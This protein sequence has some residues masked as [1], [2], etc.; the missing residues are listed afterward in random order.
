MKVPAAAAAL[1]PARSGQPETT[2]I[3]GVDKGSVPGETESR[4]DI[5]MLVRVSPVTGKAAVISIPRDTRVNMP[6]H[7]KQKINA[8]HAFGGPALTIKTVEEFTGQ[9][10]NHYVELDFQGF[11]AIVNALGGVK[12]HIDVAIHD[13]YAGDVPAGDVNLNG[14]QAL[15]LVRARHD[16]KSVP[17]GDLDR[18]KNQRRFLQAMLSTISRQRNPF[19]LMD[20]V[21]A[22]SKNAKTD[23]TFLNMLGMGRKLKGGDLQM[24]TL[25]GQPRMIGD[26]WYYI[27]DMGAFEQVLSAL[28]SAQASGIE[29]ADKPQSVPRAA[30]DSEARSSVKVAVLNG[31]RVKGVAARVAQQIISLGYAS[32]AAANAASTY[33]RTTIY[34]ASGQSAK[35]R[36]VAGDIAG[37]SDAKLEESSSLTSKYDAPVVIV[38]GSDYNPGGE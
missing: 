33:S 32:V 15:A 3:V 8:A 30:A 25:P 13:K 6:G 31:S 18:V 27:A 7:G 22:V 11:K 2:L 34:Y 36:M 14:D 10:V 28:D 29:G 16:T 24:V 17:N 38:L 4:S 26:G 12:M 23:L 35:A 19:R 37:L 9:P 1:D 5:I 21:D 20:V